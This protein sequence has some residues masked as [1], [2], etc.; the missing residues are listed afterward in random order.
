MAHGFP[1]KRN[2]WFACIQN[3]YFNV[4]TAFIPYAIKQHSKTCSFSN[5]LPMVKS[6]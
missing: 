3:I 2:L 4:D 6:C 1:N 5:L